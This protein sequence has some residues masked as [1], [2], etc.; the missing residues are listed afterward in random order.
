MNINDLL[1]DGMQILDQA[2]VSSKKEKHIN[3]F[4]TGANWV[5]SFIRQRLEKLPSLDWTP[6]SEIDNKDGYYTLLDK[7][8]NICAVYLDDITRESDNHIYDFDYFIRLPKPPEADKICTWEYGNTPS[9]DGHY[10]VVFSYGLIPF[11]IR[12]NESEGGWSN[13]SQE[14]IKS[15]KCFTKMPD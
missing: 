11:L 7:K 3:V 15:I 5:L 2:R 10:I 14:D 1:P 8:G 6:I 9:E 13:L 4:R 12:Y